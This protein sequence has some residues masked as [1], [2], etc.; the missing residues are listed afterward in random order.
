M[1]H[2]D[3]QCEK[4]AEVFE[5]THSMNFKGVTVCPICGTG[6]THKVFLQCPGISIWWKDANT[7]PTGDASGMRPKYL[8][9]TKRETAADFGG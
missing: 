8:A 7:S 9:A 1:P 2:Y 3:Y 6:E 4:C 5:A